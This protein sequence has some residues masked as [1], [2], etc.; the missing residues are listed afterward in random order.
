MVNKELVTP[1]YIIHQE[2]LEEGIHLLKTSLEQYWSNYI[3]G[4]SFKT[5]SLPWVVEKM[6]KEEFY[7]EVVSEDEYYLA[8]HVGYEKI[9]Y[10]GTALPYYKLRVQILGKKTWI[11]MIVLSQC[12][13]CF[14]I[15]AF[16]SFFTVILIHLNIPL[17]SDCI[18]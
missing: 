3:C 13:F 17:L 9:I 14:L 5:N 7:A 10:N 2:L 18:L 6:K 8:K 15:N 12:S 1:C 4:Y 11:P 16:N